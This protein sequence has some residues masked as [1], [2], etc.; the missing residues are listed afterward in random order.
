MATTSTTYP[1]TA[2]YRQW[3]TR[4][5]LAAYVSGVLAAL[6]LTLAPLAATFVWVQVLRGADTDRI[7][8]LGLIT[9]IPPVAYVA[10]FVLMVS[11]AIAINQ[12]RLSKPILLLHVVL[13]IFC[14]YG[15]AMVVEGQPRTAI[16][17]KLVG[18]MDQVMNYGSVDA[19]KDAFQNWPGFFILVGFISRLAGIESPLVLA[20]WAHVFFNLLYL[21]P[22]LFL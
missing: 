13:L 6:S 9:A 7:S 5:P 16:A 12:E 18:I 8:D 10:L 3:L 4:F 22:L 19:N 1:L 14:L 17:W 20:A 15:A 2:R 21:G 11:F